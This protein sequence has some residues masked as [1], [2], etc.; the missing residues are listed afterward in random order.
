MKLCTK[1][2]VLKV[3][4]EFPTRRN[5]KTHSYCL[6]CQRQYSK[7][8]YAEHKL[9][10]NES[11]AKRNKSHRLSVRKLIQAIKDHECTD[12][13]KKFGYWV[14]QFDHVRGV[15]KF[16]IGSFGWRSEVEVL[17]EIAKCELVC[18]N[19]HADRTHRRLLK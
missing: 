10:H 5:G 16:D 13:Q 15:K 19:C 6:L 2:A 3:E 17:A 18:A 8:H 14:M 4:S 12:C 7:L 11:R 9:K 1:C